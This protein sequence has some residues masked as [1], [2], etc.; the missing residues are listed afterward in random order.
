V[1]DLWLAVDGGQSATIAMLATGDGTIRGVGRGGPIRHHTEPG[2]EADARGSIRAAVGEA[3][4]GIGDD[5]SIV[6]CCLALTGSTTFVEAAV[7][8]LAPGAHTVVLASDA[9]AALATGTLGDGG[10]GLIAG[11]G[12]VAVAQGRRGGPLVRGGWGWILGD[13]GGGYWIGIEGLR[14]AARHLDGTGPP[15]ALT[16]ALP[17]RMGQPDMA[18]VRERMTRPDLDRAQVAGLAEEVDS[19]A[20]DGDAVAMSIMDEATRRLSSLVLATIRSAG[21]LEPDEGVVVGSG[22]VLR[23]ERVVAGLTRILGD[24]APA[25]RFVMPGVA[26]VI[27]AFYLA[28]REHGMSISE[29]TRA[30]IEQSGADHELSRKAG[31]RARS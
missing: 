11:T 3:I 18:G 30:R 2:A 17:A 28:L 31:S 6:C 1:T 20:V 24:E 14:A 4:G 27:G 5:D 12:T 7:R 8:Q 13:E 10:I 21:F 16:D 19:I 9:L 26:P 25:H 29:V 15:T 22:G 23:S